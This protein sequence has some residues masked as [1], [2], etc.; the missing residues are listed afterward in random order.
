MKR[1][2]K[3]FLNTVTVIFISWVVLVTLILFW[4]QVLING[5]TLKFVAVQLKRSGT[6]V[7]W[8]GVAD[9]RVH[10]LS[11]SNKSFSFGFM[12]P[13]I[14][15]SGVNGCFERIVLSFDLDFATLPIQVRRLGS[16]LVEGGILDI[17]SSSKPSTGK[18]PGINWN[19]WISTQK[20]NLD[21]ILVSLSHLKI[22]ELEG[23]F[24]LASDQEPGQWSGHLNVNQ[25]SDFREINA[26][27]RIRNS[28]ANGLGRWQLDLST[29]GQ[30]AA[31]A[32]GIEG[33]FQQSGSKL[34]D[35]SYRLRGF[36]S[37]RHLLFADLN[38]QYRPGKISAVVA[39]WFEAGRAKPGEHRSVTRARVDHCKIDLKER[40]KPL[41]EQWDWIVRSTSTL[42]S[43]PSSA[44]LI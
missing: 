29:D 24:H 44:F 26:D 21:T 7:T 20:M 16:L 38:G 9:I 27:F 14:R 4:P 6:E 41:P 43:R 13:C 28:K 36:I 25:L 18:N 22:N 42:I 33:M 5:H 15:S 40:E 35:F 31:G 32:L 23:D 12:K 39:A 1:R 34:S 2:L 11:F 17:E 37:G 3:Y 19:R 8:D 10:S 30:S